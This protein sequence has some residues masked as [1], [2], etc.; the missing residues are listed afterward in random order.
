MAQQ[1]SEDRAVLPYGLVAPAL[2]LTNL[3]AE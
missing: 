1:K 2:A 3:V